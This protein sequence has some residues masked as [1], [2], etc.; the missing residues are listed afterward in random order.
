MQYLAISWSKFLQIIS[1]WIFLEST[2]K[3]LLKNAKNGISRPLG[4]REIQKTKVCTVLWDTLYLVINM[5]IHLRGS[6]A[7][8]SD[9][10]SVNLIHGKS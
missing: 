7:T 10:A 5:E 1:K 2:Q 4:S 9:R 6:F 3:R 8:L